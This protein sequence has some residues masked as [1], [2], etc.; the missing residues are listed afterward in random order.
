[1]RVESATGL[2]LHLFQVGVRRELS[3]LMAGVG[4]F[5]V[6]CNVKL[7]GSARLYVVPGA[8]SPLG[9]VPA[10][11]KN[12]RV[13]R[14]PS[15]ETSWSGKTALSHEV[16]ST[17][18]RVSARGTYLAGVAAPFAALAAALANLPLKQILASPPW[19]A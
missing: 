19:S 10:N 3:R 4:N 1:M 5:A 11:V 13:T 2:E 6:E 17:A 7:A 12:P 9:Y 16:L 14:T 15:K 8:P 18:S